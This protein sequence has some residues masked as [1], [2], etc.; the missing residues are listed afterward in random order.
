MSIITQQGLLLLILIWFA[1]EMYIS[2]HQRKAWHIVKWFF[3][4]FATLLYFL[5]LS[6][7]EPF[8][9]TNFAA[10][11]LTVVFLLL[12]ISLGLIDKARG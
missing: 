1:S 9:Y 8:L 12:S 3:G 10:R 6:G 7:W 11:I 2:I 5:S 4:L